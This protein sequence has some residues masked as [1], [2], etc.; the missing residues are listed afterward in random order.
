[1]RH[2]SPIPDTWRTAPAG[3]PSRRTRKTES[4]TPERTV[5]RETHAPGLMTLA[6]AQQWTIAQ[7]PRPNLAGSKA[8]HDRAVEWARSIKTNFESRTV[9]V[10]ALWRVLDAIVQGESTAMVGDIDVVASQEVVKAIERLVPLIEEALQRDDP[11]FRPRARAPEHKD[12]EDDILAHML[13]QHRNDNVKQ[14]WQPLIRAMLLYQ[15]GVLKLRWDRRIESRVQIDQV[16]INEAGKTRYE[17]ERRDVSALVFDGP[18]FDIVEPYSFI[19]D[20][21]CNRP[22]SAQYIGDSRSRRLDELWRL[23]EMKEYL[24]TKEIQ[25]NPQSALEPSELGGFEAMQASLTRPHAAGSIL[26]G[27]QFVECL[28]LWGAFDIHGDGKPVEC[29]V[30]VVNG[31]TCVLARENPL[32]GRHRPYAVGRTAKWSKEFFNVGV[33]DLAA[34]VQEHLDVLRTITQHSTLL[35]MSPILF[36]ERADVGLPASIMNMQPGSIVQGGGRVQLITPQADTRAHLPLHMR[37]QADIGELTGA[38][39]NLSGTADTNTATESVKNL[40]QAGKRVSGL[41]REYSSLWDQ[42]LTVQH[43][44]NRQYTIGKVA[45]AAS[46]K[47]AE[48]LMRHYGFVTPASFLGDVEFDFDGLMGVFAQQTR[49]AGQAEW[50]RQ[51]GPML[52]AV[53]DQV[54]IAALM[55]SSYN[56]LVGD[57]GR[58]IFRVDP[59]PQ[60]LAPQTA[61]NKALL[62]GREVEVSPLDPHEEHTEDMQPIIEEIAEGRITNPKVIAAVTKHYLG[63]IEGA[64]QARNEAAVRARQ[65]ARRG[66]P[67][68]PDAG[69][70]A[71]ES[72]G[73]NPL[74][75]S[76]TPRGETPGAGSTQQMAKPGRNQPTP[77]TQQ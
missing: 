56:D 55:K 4:S 65:Q 60:D 22:Q 75:V 32:D 42:A 12:D 63:H 33:M 9:S 71:S 57:P 34:R 72:A 64:E 27:P 47:A 40:D 1:M 13:Q 48:V 10:R 5:I 21:D 73:T 53:A 41:I 45:W 68:G 30:V 8:V 39:N 51:W 2:P 54:N 26:H 77:Q 25:A 43:Q 7:I 18:R 58:E 3:M 61:E 50:M 46:G 6:E 23:E 62:A 28:E 59:M 29:Q 11:W 14:L 36:T 69:N 20:P 76:Q 70:K 35:G 31:T 19:I 44:M 15:V 52:P 38:P 17:I 67:E 37:Y 66:P 74:A 49:A 16:E 24:N